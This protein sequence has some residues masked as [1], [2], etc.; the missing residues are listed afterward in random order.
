M[1]APLY[2]R[3]AGP[4][5]AETVVL[6]NGGMMTALA[7]QPIT[8]T[9]TDRYRVLGLDF[10]G[11]L[12]SPGEPPPTLSGHAADVVALL[13]H[14]GIPSAHLAG[15]SFGALVGLALAAEHPQRVCSLVA[16]TATARLLPQMHEGTRL[17]R[18]LAQEAA[19]G[20]DGGKVLDA[21]VPATYSPAWIEA[22]RQVLAVRR[23]QVAA[24][25]RAWYTGLDGL[26]AALEGAD[27][28]VY[29]EHI[30]T[31]TTVI[32]GEL[33]ATFPLPNSAELAQRIAGAQLVVLPGAHHGLV[34]ENPAEAGAAIRTALDRVASTEAQP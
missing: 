1:T 27:P 3:L 22:N 6:L 28:S 9:L 34:L 31:P 8:D 20:G 5:E 23:A 33:D 14:L 12:M 21:I 7:W 26:L 11:Q 18:R 13:D 17:L 29:L 2:H 19:A 32:A 25:P 24:L 10:R 30:R 16:L 4:P 15:T